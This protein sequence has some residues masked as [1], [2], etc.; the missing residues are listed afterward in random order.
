MAKVYLTVEAER[1]SKAIYWICTLI[2]FAYF[3]YR[4]RKE[5]RYSQVKRNPPH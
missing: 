1:A 5:R 4:F 3:L 2:A